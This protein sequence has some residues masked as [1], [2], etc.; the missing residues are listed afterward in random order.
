MRAFVTE[1]TPQ[2]RPRHTSGQTLYAEPGQC[3]EQQK[4][5]RAGVWLARIR[6]GLYCKQ[7]PNGFE[8]TKQMAASIAVARTIR[9]DLVV[10][11]MVWPLGLAQLHA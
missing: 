5:P 1:H 7:V 4:M 8:L 2:P 11:T 3:V 10:D 6:C 9:T